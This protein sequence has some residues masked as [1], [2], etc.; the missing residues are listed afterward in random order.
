MCFIA[1]DFIVHPCVE[2]ILEIDSFNGIEWF[3][4][5]K[6]CTIT[7]TALSDELRLH[8][9]FDLKLGTVIAEII[10][11]SIPRPWKLIP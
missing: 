8:R 5:Q 4:Y 7:K 2:V 10:S 9:P 1:L 6:S 3:Y 11:F